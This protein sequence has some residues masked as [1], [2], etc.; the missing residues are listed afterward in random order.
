MEDK[1]SYDTK[2]TSVLSEEERRSFDGMTIDEN[3]REQSEEEIRREN[4]A[5]TNAIFGGV[6]RDSSDQTIPGIKIFTIS[7]LGWKSKLIMAAVAVAL[8][9]VLT[10]FGGLFLIGFIVLAVGAG[11][12][13]LLRKLF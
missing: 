4:R 6:R 3:G 2:Q 12:L 8:F 11:L 9:S 5:K 13:A 1:Q 10:F 7:S